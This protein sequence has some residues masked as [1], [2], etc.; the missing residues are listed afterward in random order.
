MDFSQT[1]TKLMGWA[2]SQGILVTQHPLRRNQAGIF[3]GQSFT[4]NDHY[5]ADELVCYLAHG[6][7]SVV[8]WSLSKAAVQAMFFSVTALL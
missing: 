5:P 2:S 6:L 8:R 7:G 3:D 4:L 1:L